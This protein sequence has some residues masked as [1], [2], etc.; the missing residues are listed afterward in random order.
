MGEIEKWFK[1]EL[2]SKGEKEGRAILLPASLDDLL[3]KEFPPN[4]WLVEGLIPLE[5]ITILHGQPTAGKTWLIMELAIAVSQGKPLFNHFPTEQSGVLLLDEESGE[6][7]L[8]DRFKTLRA[9]SGLPIHYLTMESSKFTE[10]FVKGLVKWCHDSSV[11]L[12][13]IDSLVRIHGGDENTAKDSARVFRLIRLL[14]SESITVIVVH[15]NTKASLNGEYGNQMRGSGDIQASVDCQLSLSRPYRDEY[16]TLEQIKNRNAPELPVIELNF[17]NHD[18]YSEFVYLGQ[19]KDGGKHAELKPIILQVV[20]TE[21][22]IS[23]SNIHQ[24]LLELGHGTH[25]KTLRKLLGTMEKVDESIAKSK[26]KA[27]SYCYYIKTESDN[28]DEG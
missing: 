3:S 13:M 9:S 17:I 25:P 4:R 19:V 5:G 27:N 21:P 20:G 15:H 7:L 2:R 28:P 11:S 14:T 18:T 12:V 10:P 8:H 16:L 24:Q 23:Q 6:W 26:G 22:G 1:E